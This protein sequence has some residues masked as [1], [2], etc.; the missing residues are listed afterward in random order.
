MAGGLSKLTPLIKLIPAGGGQDGEWSAQL[1]SC[2]IRSIME[3]QT[4]L[5]KMATKMIVHAQAYNFLCERPY[6]CIYYHLSY[7]VFEEDTICKK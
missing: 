2:I 5:S 4:I 7:F 6:A 3:I 1:K